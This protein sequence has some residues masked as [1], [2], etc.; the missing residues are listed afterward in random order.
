MLNRSIRDVL[1]GQFVA[2]LP[3][4]AT[5]R[6]AARTMSERHIASVAIEGETGNLVGI[7]TERDMLDRVVTA[8]RDPDRTTM[9]EVMTPRPVT[10]KATSTV[11]HAIAEMKACGLRHLPVVDGEEVVGV[12]SMRDFVG[13]DVAAV[14]HEQAARIAV[15]RC[16]R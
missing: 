1:G 6:D 10:I 7:F 4:D 16:L 9:S 13:E 2:W 14:D 5:A 15:W 8:G 12:V 3:P 11:G